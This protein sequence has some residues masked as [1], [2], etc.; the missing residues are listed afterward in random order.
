M[1]VCNFVC[2]C[3]CVFACAVV[4]FMLAMLATLTLKTGRIS[5]FVIPLGSPYFSTLSHKQH[6]FREKV[7]EHKISVLIFSTTFI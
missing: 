7:V 1:T 6:D 3:A 5:S 4:A 2:V